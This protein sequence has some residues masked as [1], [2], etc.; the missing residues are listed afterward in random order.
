MKIVQDSA[1]QLEVWSADW[2]FD[3]PAR[4]CVWC[5]HRYHIQSYSWRG[6]KFNLTGERLSSKLLDTPEIAG[7]PF[8]LLTAGRV[9]SP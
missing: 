1:A 2:N 6:G 3:P 7:K 5:P 8:T 4:S 9:D